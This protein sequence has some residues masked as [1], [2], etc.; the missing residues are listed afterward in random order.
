MLDALARCGDDL[1]FLGDI[2]D[3]WVA[4]PRYEN[5]LH[6]QFLGWCRRQKTRRSVGFIE[7]NHEYYLTDNHSEAF[8]WC[9]SGPFHRE[10]EGLLFCHGDQIN[11][12]DSHYL[13][14]RKLSKNRV[15]RTIL[16]GL[17]LGPALVEHLKRRLKK[18]NMAFRR[19]LPLDQIEAYAEACGRE[20]IHTAFVGHFHQHHTCRS[21][22]GVR[23][24]TLPAWFA[25][26]CV[27][28]Y[29]PR[30]RTLET[31]VPV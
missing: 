12:Q 25:T 15:T 7:G 4:L 14:F 2:F 16:A 28:R 22:Q 18:T 3:L 6:R 26:G 27:S 24:C 1:V 31:L 17:P 11:R 19:E 9:A 29:D 13:T 8:T 30:N 21:Y 23:L 20:G 10:S 5:E